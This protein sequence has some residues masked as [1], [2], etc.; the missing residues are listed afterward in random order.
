MTPEEH[1]DVVIRESA[2]CL[3]TLDSTALD[4]PVPPCPGW[5][6]ADLAWHLAEVQLFWA[7]IVDGVLDDPGAVQRPVRPVDEELREL[8]AGASTALVQALMARRP[9]ERCWSWDD[10]GHHVGWVARRQAHEALIHRV[11]A[12]LAAGDPVSDVAPALAADGVD[13]VLTVVMADLPKWGQFQPDGSLAAITCTDA[14][15]TWTLAMGR[16][17]G[18]SPSSDRD[19]DHPMGLVVEE[20]GVPEAF[21]SGPAWQLDRWLWGRGGAETVRLEGSREVTDRL[22]EAA[23]AA[24]L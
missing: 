24:T 7:A 23:A 14:D 15:Q 20:D 1:I 19:Y 22:R 8:L 2:R 11:D 13:E 5:T 3:A 9:D 17:T 6:A 16:F 21:V 12:Q 10:D 18:T 4:A